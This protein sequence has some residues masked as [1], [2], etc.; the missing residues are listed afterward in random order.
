MPEP[1]KNNF[2]TE[3]INALASA[4]KSA[5]PEFDAE[6]FQAAATQNLG[7]LELKE[8]S[9]QIAEALVSHL[10]TDF[11]AAS[12]ALIKTLKPL[13][14]PDDAPG[15]SSWIIMPMAD[16]VART[17]LPH[18]DAAMDVLTEL[19]SRFSSEFAVRP[20]LAADLSA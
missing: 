16:Y 9:N 17:G 10:P 13:D 18:F 6:G 12:A 2:N 19:T 3:V 14:A 8:R 15:L 1:F 11:A 20:F 5:L 7:A 4:L